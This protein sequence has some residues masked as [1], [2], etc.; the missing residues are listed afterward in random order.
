MYYYGS[1]VLLENNLNFHFG[2]RYIKLSIKDA[3]GL[4]AELG[5]SYRMAIKAVNKHKLKD[6]F[7]NN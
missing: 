6:E 7:L 2:L 4:M 5:V 1:P 3:T